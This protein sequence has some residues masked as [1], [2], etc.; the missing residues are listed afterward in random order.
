MKIDRKKLEWYLKN[1]RTNSKDQEITDEELVDQ[2][3]TWI[4]RNP[5]CVDVKGVSDHGR[6]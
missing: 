5:K 6:F 2:L 3:A 1:I 4:E